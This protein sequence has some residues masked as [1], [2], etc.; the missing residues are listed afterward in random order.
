[1]SGKCAD[2]N[3]LY[4]AMA[5]SVGLPAR[6]VYGIRVAPSAFGFKAL[7][8]GSANITKA[9]HCRAEV[10]LA[11]S[12]W[13]PVDPADVRKVVLEEP[14]GNLAIT[15][16][17]VKRAR[18]RLFGSWEMNWIAYNYAHDVTLPSSS[19]GS[20]PYFMYPQGETAKGRLDSLD[21]DNFRYSITVKE[22][23]T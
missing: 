14:P 10:W 15:D 3:A 11:D 2:L 6:D 16:E 1:L 8:A 21:P 5:R 18:T 23:T 22:V 13:T 12:G 20:L 4:V 17:R 7:G 19:R 9:Q